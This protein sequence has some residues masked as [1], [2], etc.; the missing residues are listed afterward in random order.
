M[1]GVFRI[2][3]ATRLFIRN[4]IHNARTKCLASQTLR[5][6][7]GRLRHLPYRVVRILSVVF[8]FIGPLSHYLNK[9]FPMK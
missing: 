2:K 8:C 7:A 6:E 9:V 3:E 1:L 4:E 5:A